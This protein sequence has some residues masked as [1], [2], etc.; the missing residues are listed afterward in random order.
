MR[1]ARLTT[2]ASVPLRRS[3]RG[4]AACRSSAWAHGVRIRVGLLGSRILGSRVRVRVIGF[5]FGLGGRSGL[6]FQSARVRL[7]FGWSRLARFAAGL[8]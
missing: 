5:G 1:V 8:A 6:E 3:A 7:V 4:Q 2:S